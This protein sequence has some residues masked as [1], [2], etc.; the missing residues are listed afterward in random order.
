[1]GSSSDSFPA[2]S[3]EFLEVFRA[4]ADTSG[5]MTF[6]QFMTVALYHPAVGYYR[7]SRPRVGRGKET[8][9]FTATTSGTIFG[10]LVSSACA[11]LLRAAGKNPASHTFVEIGAEPGG[12]GVLTNVTNPFA[13]TEV[14]RIGEPLNLRGECVIFSN[15]LFD[16]Q[17]CRRTVY[18]HGRWRTIGVRIKDDRLEETE[19]DM[20]DGQSPWPGTEGY[21]FDQP[22]AAATL[23]DQ[24]AAEPWTGIFV[25]IDYGKTFR[26]LLEETPA[27]TL[28]A[29]FRHSQSNDLLARPGEQDLTCHIC[30]DWIE[31]SLRQRG[32]SNLILEFQ[33][34][35]F[36]RHAGDFL[37]TV[38][39]RDASQF[40][41]RKQALLQLLH[42]SHM[43]QKFQVL[44]A[45]R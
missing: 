26:A 22:V 14:R 8:D 18:R 17:P 33:E 3:A 12:S 7:Q 41:P 16:A 37:A 15:E 40:S 29:Y 42:P 43:G 39:A 25:A 28:R 5:G 4:L 20:L 34:A 2:P 13:D 11:K 1:M 9:F 10:E 35:F 27:G 44:H 31:A 24:I 21:R 45:I 19:L 23:S 30:W 36:I 38:S 32:F 6:E